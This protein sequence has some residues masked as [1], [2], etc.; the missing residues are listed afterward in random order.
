MTRQLQM[1]R[2]DAED[3][4]DS[5]ITQRRELDELVKKVQEEEKR[6]KSLLTRLRG[7]QGRI[8]EL[9][10]KIKKAKEEKSA[11]DT[12]EQQR[13]QIV[14]L[15]LQLKNADDKLDSMET[16]L[17]ELKKKLIITKDELE[18]FREEAEEA[19]DLAHDDS[20]DSGLA[21]EASEA[22]QRA[23]QYRLQSLGKEEELNKLKHLASDLDQQIDYLEDKIQREE[24]MNADLKLKLSEAVNK[25]DMLEA[26][27]DISSPLNSLQIQN[28]QLM[29]KANSQ[30]LR[31]NQAEERAQQLAQEIRHATVE[32]DTYQ[33]QVEDLKKKLL[34][35]EDQMQNVDHSGTSK[36][37]MLS[38]AEMDLMKAESE[39]NSLRAK[40]R[41]ARDKLQLATDRA[42]LPTDLSRDENL[43]VK[44][45][46]QQQIN[47]SLQDKISELTTQFKEQET[48]YHS[49]D[50]ETLGIRNK[51][52]VL[53]SRL[54]DIESKN[55]FTG[56]MQQERKKNEA[57]QSQISELRLRT[58]QAEDRAQT[59]EIQKKDAEKARQEA[60]RA[61][62]NLKHKMNGLRQD[63]AKERDLVKDR[64]SKLRDLDDEIATLTDQLLSLIHI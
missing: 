18:T 9:N 52:Q 14:S 46:N 27:S 51:I 47:A 22:S 48:S 35:A 43:R 37:Q 13:L 15:K 21:S 26:S 11:Q 29:A 17:E 57:L 20:I 28:D 39:V 61:A 42:S 63:L 55:D 4:D 41:D 12:A 19:R 24:Q 64:D 34:Q 44:L 10:Q 5:S 58:R 2:L 62:D 3:A 38:E 56:A 59:L 53:E 49:L 23:E 40:L 45:K 60:E 31:A 6:N 25:L 36:H 33:A 50:N 8:D 30:E 16:E 54:A 1:Y 32:K 7:V